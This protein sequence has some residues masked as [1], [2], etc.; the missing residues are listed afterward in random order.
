LCNEYGNEWDENIGD[1]T[2]KYMTTLHSTL[3]ESPQEAWERTHVKP[4]N[5]SEEEIKRAKCANLG[6]M[7][8]LVDRVMKCGIRNKKRRQKRK[9]LQRIEVGDIVLVRDDRKDK[10]TKEKDLLLKPLFP[11]KAR[12]K[13][14]KGNGTYKV[15]FISGPEPFPDSSRCY[16]VKLLKKDSISEVAN[17]GNLIEFHVNTL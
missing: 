15:E 4:L 14:I 6:H 7:K 5:K 13:D 16:R 12:V 10:K 9:K 17:N 3:G 1:I 2:E 11:W 8:V